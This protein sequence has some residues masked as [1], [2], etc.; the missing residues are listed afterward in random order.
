MLRRRHITPFRCHAISPLQPLRR[1]RHFFDT[2]FSPPRRFSSAAAACQLIFTPPIAAD[3]IDI[4]A[5]RRL[6]LLRRHCRRRHFR[7]AAAI[8]FA[9]SRHAAILPLSLP[10]QHYL[11]RHY[12]I[13]PLITLIHWLAAAMLFSYDTPYHFRRAACAELPDYAASARCR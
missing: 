12:A 1:L 4:A 7:L 8:I 2:L 3:A 13:T 9:I 5:I 11:I 10:L 6:P